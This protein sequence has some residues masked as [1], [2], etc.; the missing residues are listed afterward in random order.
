MNHET[1][2][3]IRDAANDWYTGRLSGFAAMTV[4]YS[5][6]NPVKPTAAD[7]NWAR[8]M[9]GVPDAASQRSTKGE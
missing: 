2:R 8:Q 4:I 3:L 6:T 5:L 9:L 7:M 1:Q